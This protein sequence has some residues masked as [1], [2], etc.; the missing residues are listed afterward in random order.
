MFQFLNEQADEREVIQILGKHFNIREPCGY[1]T[2]GGTEGN[3]SALWWHQKYLYH[4][5]EKD[6]KELEEQA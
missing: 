3:M 1:V 4:T 2:N 5:S 6:V